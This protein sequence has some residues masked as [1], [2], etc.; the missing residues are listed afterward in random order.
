MVLQSVTGFFTLMGNPDLP[1]VYTVHHIRSGKNY[2]VRSVTVSQEV[3]R[4]TCFTCTASFKRPERST[5]EYQKP[6]KLHERY[7][8]VLEGK[9]A[10]DHP[11]YSPTEIPVYVNRQNLGADITDKS[12]LIIH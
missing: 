5:L 9:Q 7:A 2:Q 1:F 11:D 8:E 12:A 10:Q 6:G 3:T 4:G